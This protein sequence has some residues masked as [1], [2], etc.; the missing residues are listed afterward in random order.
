M[1][2]EAEGARAHSPGT[3]WPRRALVGLFVLA[4]ALVGGVLAARWDALM[5]RLARPPAAGAGG[6]LP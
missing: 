4:F 3:A 2:R 6:V 5:E 1:R